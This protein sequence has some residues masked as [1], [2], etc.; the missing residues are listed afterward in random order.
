MKRRPLCFV[1]AIYLLW[2][3]YAFPAF[4]AEP[5]MGVTET[6]FCYAALKWAVENNVTI[7][8]SDGLFH[9]ER[10]CTKKSALTFMWRAYEKTEE[11]A[12]GDNMEEAIRWAERMGFEPDGFGASAPLFPQGF[13][14]VPLSL[15]ALKGFKIR[16]RHR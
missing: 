3:G 12:D 15:P 16:G 13:R 6:A 9:P 11:S 10:T 1:I 8:Y 7:G 2:L 5:Y 14:Q 4:A